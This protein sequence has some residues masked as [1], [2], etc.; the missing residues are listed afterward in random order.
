MREKAKA[1]IAI[2]VVEESI[3]HQKMLNTIR[4]MFQKTSMDNLAMLYA[5]DKCFYCCTTNYEE[6]MM[7]RREY[8][9]HIDFGK[10]GNLNGRSIK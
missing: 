7:R 10:F 5:K 6:L 9:A 4:T 2:R 3:N 8:E 1:K